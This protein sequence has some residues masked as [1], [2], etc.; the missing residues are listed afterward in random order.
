MRRNIV[1]LLI[2]GLFTSLKTL[3][4]AVIVIFLLLNYGKV[5]AYDMGSTTYRIWSSTISVGGTDL[6]TS[7]SYMMRDTIGENV[8]GESTSTSYKLR[9]GYQPMLE[10]Y[11]SLSLSTSSVTM[12]P[13]IGGLTGGV[14]TG[15]YIIT[16]LTENPA[17][18]SLFVSASTSPALKSGAYSFADYTLAAANTPDYDWSIVSSSSEFGFSPEGSDITQSFK[19]NGFSCA[20]STQDTPDRCWYN[21]ST[22]TENISLSYSSNHPSGSQTTIKLKAQSGTSHFQQAGSYQATITNTAVAN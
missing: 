20:T 15:T 8:V 18:Y 16:V 12:F 5:F 17:G 14:A 7:T 2:H 13:S 9:S 4:S 11:I 22:S 19:D 21:F 6:Q 1:N 3:I 10:T